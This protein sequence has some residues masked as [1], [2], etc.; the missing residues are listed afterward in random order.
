[1][2]KANDVTYVLR[3]DLEARYDPAR[4]FRGKAYILQT[5]D[6]KTLYSYDKAVATAIDGIIEVY[7]ISSATTLRHVKEFIRQQGGKASTRQQI[8]N[9]YMNVKTEL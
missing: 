6:K 8:I 5:Y 2:D 3:Y 4:S 9:D 7:E 1:M